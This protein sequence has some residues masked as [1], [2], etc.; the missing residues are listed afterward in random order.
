MIDQAEKHEFEEVVVQRRQND[1]LWTM[2]LPK[3]ASIP[4][5]TSPL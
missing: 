4:G 3:G 2:L 1:V 5:R